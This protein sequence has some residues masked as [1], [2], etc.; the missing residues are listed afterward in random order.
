MGKKE[1]W[2]S[3]PCPRPTR[4]GHNWQGFKDSRSENGSSQG[5]NLALTGL[6]VPSSQ[7]SGGARVTSCLGVWPVPV[8][9]IGCSSP[10]EDP[11]SGPGFGHFQV[12]FIKVV[13]F[14]LGSGFEE[15]FCGGRFPRAPESGC[16]YASN[17][18][19]QVM[20]PTAGRAQCRRLGCHQSLSFRS[21]RLHQASSTAHNGVLPRWQYPSLPRPPGSG[22]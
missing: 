4:R 8:P 16:W 11:E 13:S 17:Y 7:G 6:C 5:Q 22:C 10:T 1:T 3:G 14:P 2:E 9:H 19:N 12:E 15:G 20:R 21:P 18:P